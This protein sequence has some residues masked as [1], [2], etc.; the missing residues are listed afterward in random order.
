M[1]IEVINRCVE[2]GHTVFCLTPMY[3]ELGLDKD[4]QAKLLYLETHPKVVDY[5][6]GTNMLYK[7]MIESL[8][9][10]K[11]LTLE[12]S[13]YGDDADLYKKN[14]NRDLYDQFLKTFIPFI[15]RPHSYGGKIYIRFS[16]KPNKKMMAMLNI[17][18][19]NGIGVTFDEIKNFN[20]GGKIPHGSLENEHPLIIKKGICPTA[21][22]G[23]IFENGDVGLCYMNDTHKSVIFGNIFETELKDIFKCKEYI[24]IIEDMEKN[25]YS[26]ICEKCNE[27]FEMLM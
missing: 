19:H 7:D 16:R 26:G 2:Y 18:Q 3:G 5:F 8:D 12:V 14:T 15:S 22:M 20:L 27:R 21:K 9:G 10:L 13:L 4:L 17:A 25:I 1:F 6:F 24:K 11:K 23:C